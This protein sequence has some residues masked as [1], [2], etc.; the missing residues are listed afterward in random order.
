MRIMRPINAGGEWRL[1]LYKWFGPTFLSLTRVVRHPVEMY[2]QEILYERLFSNGLS[3]LGLEN[4][5]YP[6]GGAASFSLMYLLLRAITELPVKRI[7]ELGC[8]QSTLLLDALSRIR[9]L[10]IN[11]LEH[12][13]AWAQRIQKDVTHEITC[14]GLVDR[15]VQNRM[16]LVY[17]TEVGLDAAPP[18]LLLVDGPQ[19]GSRYSRW[20]ALQWIE[21]GL[22]DDF[23][24]V[25]DDAERRGE[26]DT[27]EKTLRLLR[28]QG[29]TFR[30]RFYYSIRWQFVIASGNLTP[31]TH[32]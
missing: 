27:I 24:I 25:F 17:D 7:V 30:T 3:S 32:F 28:E 13:W 11:T 19:G 4:R 18:D 21:R 6:T 1:R 10:E 23:I 14:A 16:T 26:I 8:G 2:G 9:P 29:R 5:Y 15:V 12:D 22:G 31:A 20:A